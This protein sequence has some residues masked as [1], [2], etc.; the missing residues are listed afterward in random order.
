MRSRFRKPAADVKAPKKPRPAPKPF[1]A[2]ASLEMALAILAA[3][4]KRDTITRRDPAGDIVARWVLPLECA[5]TGNALMKKA[6]YGG[7]CLSAAKSRV[8]K[9]MLEQSGGKR[10]AAPL[11][12]RPHVRVVI[13]SSGAEDYDQGRTKFIVDRLQP[14]KK[15]KPKK[16]AKHVWDAIRAKAPPVD[17]NWITN[18]TR[19]AI[20]LASWQEPAPPKKGCVLVELYTGAV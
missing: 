4:P 13:F 19:E 18:D 6:A 12:G 10:A 16:M 20:D 3:P 5:P 1:D 15:Q 11:P 17:L 2:Q 7:W 8:R 14:G 9:L